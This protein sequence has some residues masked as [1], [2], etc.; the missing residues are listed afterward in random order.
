M[1]HHQIFQKVFTQ[2]HSKSFDIQILSKTS[3]C[4]KCTKWQDG[5]LNQ[6]QALG[7]ADVGY[8]LG[9]CG[10]VGGV[11]APAAVCPRQDGSGSPPSSESVSL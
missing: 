10:G 8:L 2:T 11:D 4:K 6:T 9:G 1:K 3:I 5:T 7:T